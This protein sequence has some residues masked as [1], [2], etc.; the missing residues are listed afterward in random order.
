M[1]EEIYRNKYKETKAYRLKGKLY[2]KC[3]YCKKLFRT[4]PC[5]LKRNRKN[6]YCSNNCDG[7]SRSY[8]NTFYKWKGGYI[9]KTTGYK[10]VRYKEKQVEEHRL[11]MMKH[12]NRELT[13]D[14]IIHHIN[15]NK[16]DNRIKNLKLTNK[17]DHPK[18][19]PKN[20]K[21]ICLKCKTYKKHHARGLCDTCYH[22]VLM[23]GDLNEYEKVGKV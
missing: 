11:V 13:S 2:T 16:L 6:F 17:Y 20:N 8:N 15:G 4:F 9:S 23:K 21:R 12:L 5:Y 19:H 14:E 1:D 22:Y 7:K 18:L 3:D 10:V